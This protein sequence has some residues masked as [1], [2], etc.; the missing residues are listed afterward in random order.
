MNPAQTYDAMTDE[1]IVE[2]VR[3]R[4][5]GLLWRAQNKPRCEMLRKWIV[6]ELAKRPLLEPLE[7]T[8]RHA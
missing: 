8:S 3:H 2:F 4:R 6:D 5:P 1:E 7:E